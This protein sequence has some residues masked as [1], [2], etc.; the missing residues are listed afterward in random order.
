MYY[1]PRALAPYLDYV[2][3]QAFDFYTPDR[4]KKLADFPSPLYELS[5]RRSDE[6]IDAWVKYWWVSNFKKDHVKY[7]ITSFSG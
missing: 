1:D 5:E 4:N 7:F 6:N 2:V 3:L